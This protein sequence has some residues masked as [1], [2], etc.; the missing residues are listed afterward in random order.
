MSFTTRRTA[1]AAA[2][3]T[4]LGSSPTIYAYRPTP[5]RIGSGWLDLK[6]ADTEDSTYGD[7]RVSYD[8]VVAIGTD[9]QQAEQ[10]LD[11]I[12]APLLEAC[13][14]QGRGITVRPLVY[15]IDGTDFYCAVA[16]LI[17][18]VGTI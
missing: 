16:T 7:L 9:P 10:R 17:T 2:L 3:T 5:L 15:N 14:D 6:Q 1:I 18:E 13:A 12:S 8:V 11:E 4:A